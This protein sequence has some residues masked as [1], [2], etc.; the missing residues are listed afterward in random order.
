MSQIKIEI[1]RKDGNHAFP[2]ARLEKLLGAEFGT[3]TTG[4][5]LLILLYHDCKNVI[6]SWLDLWD[7]G[8]RWPDD[9][10]PLVMSADI[11]EGDDAEER[12]R[13]SGFLS[14]LWLKTPLEAWQRPDFL[15]GV[16]SAWRFWFARPRIDKTTAAACARE[17]IRD[18]YIS[19]FLMDCGVEE[20]SHHKHM[21]PDVLPKVRVQEDKFRKLWPAAYKTLAEEGGFT[22]AATTAD[23]ERDQFLRNNLHRYLPQR[24][25]VRWA[26]RR[27][28]RPKI[29]VIDDEAEA[30]CE[31]LE[32]LRI[33]PEEKH[34][35]FGHLCDFF[36]LPDSPPTDFE[37][38]QRS[39][40]EFLRRPAAPR[41]GRL[42][43]VRSADFILLDLSMKQKP[44]EELAGFEVL[45]ML[46]RECPEIPVVIHSSFADYRNVIR[47][48]QNG[49]FWFKEK[50]SSEEPVDPASL[51]AV[52]EDIDRRS[53]WDKELKRIRR[54]FEYPD[55]PPRREDLDLHEYFWS[56]LAYPLPEGKVEVSTLGAGIGGATT[57]RLSVG[58]AS[59]DVWGTETS[60]AAATFIAKIDTS[61]RMTSERERYRRFI[62]PYLGSRA[63]RVQSK[64]VAADGKSAIAYS[65][66]GTPMSAGDGSRHATIPLD[67]LIDKSLKGGALPFSAFAPIFEELFD[68]VGRMHAIRQPAREKWADHAFGE[69]LSLRDTFANRLPADYELRDVELFE[70]ELSCG[71][72]ENVLHENST[73]TIRNAWIQDLEGREITVAG[74][75]P[76]GLF[77]AKLKDA[78]PPGRDPHSLRA[79]S[80]IG[81]RG[82]IGR[83]RREAVDQLLD[84]DFREAAV[85][86]VNALFKTHG[87]QA[88]DPVRDR[89][90]L[91]GGGT[92]L[93]RILQLLDELSTNSGRRRFLSRERT[94]IVHGD[95]NLGNV[96]VEHT[97]AGGPSA[98]TLWLIDFAASRRDSLVHDFAECEADLLTLL[99]KE[100]MQNAT[101]DL[102]EFLTSLNST[103]LSYPEELT[104]NPR[105]RFLFD[106]VQ[107]IRHA[108]SRAGVSKVEYLA[109]LVVYHI[110]VL[111]IS[112]K[113]AFDKTDKKRDRDE[114]V[115]VQRLAWIAA[116]VAARELSRTYVR[117]SSS[118][119]YRVTDGSQYLVCVSHSRREQQDAISLKPITYSSLPIETDRAS[120]LA[121][122]TQAEMSE[123]HVE[124]VKILDLP[125]ALD[126]LEEAWGDSFNET[127]AISN[128][129]ARLREL[130]EAPVPELKI[131]GTPRFR[132][133][134]GQTTRRS[135]G[136]TAAAKPPTDP[137]P[138][139]E[140]QTVWCMQVVDVYLEASDLETL[141]AASKSTNRWD[142]TERKWLE[143]VSE[144]D[145]R[146]RVAGGDEIAEMSKA[147][148][149]PPVRISASGLCR[150][151]IGDRFLLG[152]SRSRAAHGRSVLTPLG[153]AFEFDDRGR[154]FLDR[155]GAEYENQRDLRIRIPAAK[156]G[157]FRTWFEERRDRETTPLRELREEL[158]DEYAVPGEWT[159]P[160]FRLRR[161][162]RQ[163][164]VTDRPG[165]DGQLTFRFIEIFD[166]DLPPD[167]AAA[168][169]RFVQAGEAVSPDSAGGRVPATGGGAAHPVLRLRLLSEPEIRGWK[170]G[171]VSLGST[172][173][174]LLE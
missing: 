133:V 158:K 149:A 52:L 138:D 51:L 58:A 63:G 49:A 60:N 57:N 132:Y 155:L 160:E 16:R 94:A 121:V 64:L 119:V 42:Q 126:K 135:S 111:K 46:N 93:E 14:P 27:V 56:K 110:I 71:P 122:L 6:Q 72:P 29:L 125:G 35:S 115:W 62:H 113:K 80:R 28:L 91:A 161:S 145:V 37:T 4:P 106:A 3:A 168:V 171:P 90:A 102:V 157:K 143:L 114:R 163:R 144:D 77:R 47:A 148:L 87:L 43:D 78:I 170:A 131:T 117:L 108:A 33:S 141:V 159:N 41:A 151:R 10:I 167:V 2:H 30:V 19:R 65:Y 15:E 32:K 146:S 85:Q 20:D 84:S 166:V 99:R 98:G 105:L 118:R 124:R 13:E 76:T 54:D 7:G 134:M 137:L 79:Y 88:H 174:L 156:L 100:Y 153:G 95:L 152:E 89:G 55:G 5:R 59:S 154:I 116:T 61:A 26:M 36:P 66:S 147:L 31:R 142:G 70:P 139:H 50:V 173:A 92:L 17:F 103:A 45:R 12:R 75:G 23:N 123:R 73:L 162:L 67:V 104:K 74:Y 39:V 140:A 107:T 68:S 120:E 109:A 8:S 81:A 11:G 112:R 40:S 25:G 150:I 130:T 128:L 96:L 1:R 129:E 169:E 136:G 24:R 165:Q 48:V 97:A 82:T 9:V 34:L 69:F 101:I 86:S 164:E 127:V 172:V 22:A 18:A 44:K 38:L 83:L 53:G 21:G